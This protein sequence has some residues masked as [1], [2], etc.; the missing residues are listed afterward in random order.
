MIYE[1][2]WFSIDVL[3]YQTVTGKEN[4][5][6]MDLGTTILEHLMCVCV[7]SMSTQ[8]AQQDLQLCQIHEQEFLRP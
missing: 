3:N 2:K 8:W 1:Q 4:T 5:T 7:K 6:C